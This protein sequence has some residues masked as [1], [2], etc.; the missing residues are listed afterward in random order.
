MTQSTNLD[1][2]LIA[3][4]QLGKDLTANAA[5]QAFANTIAETLA[6]DASL[7]A[8]PYTIPYSSAEGGVKTALQFMRMNVT[9]ALS[10]DWIGIV[11]AKKHLFV[12]TNGTTGGHSV[13]VK[14]TGMTGV[15]VGSGT[16]QL[17]YNNGTDVIAVLAGTPG[18]AGG[19]VSIEYTFDTGTTNA[20][21]GTGKI[22]IN[23]ATENTATAIYAQVHDDLGVDWTAVLDTLDAS[24]ST[25]KGQFRLYNKNDLSK[26]LLFNITSRTTHVNYREYA[27]VVTGSSAASPFS[28]GDTL[29]LAFTRSGDQGTAGA[30]GSGGINPNLL[31]NGAMDID[32]ANEAASVSV[33]TTTSPYITDQWQVPFT[34]AATGLTAQQV[35]DAPA[36]FLNS[37]KVTIG[38]GSAT[39]NAGDSL[40]I[41]QS[42]EGISCAGL[43]FGGANA[44]ALSVS[45]WVKSNITGTFGYTLRNSA[46]NRSYVGTFTISAANTWQQVTAANI[47]GDTSGTWLTAQGVVG[48]SLAVTLMSGSTGQGTA[49]SWQAANVLTTSSQT[50]LAATS[51]NNFQITGAKVE[52]SATV[53]AFDRRPF[54]DEL[55]RCLRHYEKSYDSGVAIGTNT[56]AGMFGVFLPLSIANGNTID[57]YNPYL[58]HKAKTPTITLYAIGGTSGSISLGGVT[59]TAAA[60]GVGRKSFSGLQNNSGGTWTAGSSFVEYQYV[61]DARI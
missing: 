20:D 35:A 10:A 56:Q 8:S 25:V 58:V 31:I 5:F 6:I 14:V 39:L 36:G 57:F 29:I 34:G 46:K 47:G 53:T 9:G 51:T 12:I 1:V 52:Q 27:V 15:T 43:N 50:N 7:N 48:L 26:W 3:P 32:Q 16:S 44:A 55:I 45:F 17:V 13:T 18:A 37:L 21:P 4:G 38:T 60:I 54:A 41:L 59:K 30:A 42:I 2:T 40:Q 61:I 33:A 22:R 19:A 28:A 23:N 24:S 11:P 49:G